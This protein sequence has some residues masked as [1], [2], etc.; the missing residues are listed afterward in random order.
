MN[1]YV[2]RENSSTTKVNE[3]KIRSPITSAY[4]ERFENVSS[5]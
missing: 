4:C 5:I 2:E 1:T 3:N